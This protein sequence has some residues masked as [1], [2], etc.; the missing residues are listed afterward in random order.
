MSHIDHLNIN[1]SPLQLEN[2]QLTDDL[3]LARDKL[4]QAYDYISDQTADLVHFQRERDEA[5]EALDKFKQAERERSKPATSI[6]IGSDGRHT[7]SGV[8]Q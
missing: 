8:Q 4:Q 3:R 2:N 1:L 5:V 6:A 7:R